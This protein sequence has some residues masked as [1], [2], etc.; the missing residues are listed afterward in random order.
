MSITYKELREMDRDTLTTLLAEAKRAGRDKEAAKIA[1]E[2]RWRDR[3][4]DFAF[5][6]IN[7]DGSKETLPLDSDAD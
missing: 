4:E 3:S 6:K 1:N 7:P 2:L 5:I